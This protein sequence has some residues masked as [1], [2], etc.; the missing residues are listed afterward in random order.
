[1]KR[2]IAL[3]MAII[4][5]VTMFLAACGGTKTSQDTSSGTT[6]S[7]TGSSGSTSDGAT[8]T[9]KADTPAKEPV[10]VKWATWENR[11]MA[12][13]MA[14]KFNEK[15]PDIKVVIDD[16]G[17]WFGNEQLAKRAASGELPDV[18]NIENP[19]IPLQNKWLLDLKPFLDK[20]TDKKF[21][22]NFVDT[23]TF[24]GMVFMLPSYIYIHGILVNKSLLEAN[25]TPVP[26]YG[27]TIDEFKNILIKTTKG[28]TMGINGIIDIVKHIPAQINDNLGW[29]CWDGSKYALGDEWKYAVDTAK[30]LYDKKV[31]IWQ[32]EEQ[33]SNLPEQ[34]EGADGESVQ[35]KIKNMYKERFGEEDAYSVFLKGNVATW[36]EFSWGLSFD[37]NEKFGGFDWDFYPFPVKDKGDKSRPGLVCDSLAISAKAKDPEAAFRFIKY[38]SFDP[39]SFDDRVEIMNN[40]NKEEAMKKYP[41]IT[42]DR[43]PE[44]LTFSHVPAINDQA[45]RDKWCDLNNVKPGLR[46]MVNNMGTGYIDGFKFVPDFDTAYHKTIEKAIKEEIFTGKKTAADLAAELEQKAT[47]ITQTAIANMKK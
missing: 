23:G 30:E 24:E 44:F 16:F 25:N 18:F 21:Y 42:E 40:Y 29:G 4:M 41:E 34:S 7:E 9:K 17:G 15:N 2:K 10:V 38:I 26:D 11:I 19:V 43:F 39:S 37:K 33:F 8:D 28:Q 36:L 22:Q 31:A 35:D 5:G 14:A 6:V 27:W 45:V 13:E 3:L 1:M 12:E 46:E 47:E 20:E 32:L